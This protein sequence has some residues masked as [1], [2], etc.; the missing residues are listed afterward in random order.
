MNKKKNKNNKLLEA[1]KKRFSKLAKSTF[2]SE[3]SDEV[4]GDVPMT[5]VGAEDRCVD[6][7]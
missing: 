7:C 4:D 3:N 6:D 5:I 2:N 1:K